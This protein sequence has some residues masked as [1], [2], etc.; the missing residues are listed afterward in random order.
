MSVCELPD[1]PSH[2]LSLSPSLSLPLSLSPSLSPS[3]P[4]PFSL[5]LS[6]SPSLWQEFVPLVRPMV[7]DT[8]FYLHQA[9]Q[10]QK[11]I[12]VEGANATMLDIDFGVC[13]FTQ[14]F[15]LT[16]P[17]LYIGTYPY[18]TSSNCT[19]GGVCTGL[20]IPPCDVAMV[21]GVMKAY[22]TRVGSGVMPTELLGVSEISAVCE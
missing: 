10:E 1:P 9:I 12:I 21:Y 3:L 15:V 11:K 4:L 19:V 22:S 8:V 18:V 20:G 16:L 7:K 13:V 2:F 5:S 6:L 17:S 14:T